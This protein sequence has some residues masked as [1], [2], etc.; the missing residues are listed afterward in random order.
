MIRSEET[1]LKRLKL[2]RFRGFESLDAGLERTT[3]LLGPNSS[4][5]TSVLHAIRMAI[6]ALDLALDQEDSHE[7][8]GRIRVCR[9]LIVQD[10]PRLVAVDDWPEVFEGGSASE[11]DRLDV[12]LELGGTSSEISNIDVSISYGRNRQPKLTVVVACP[13]ALASVKALPK[14][15]PGRPKRLGDEVRRRAPR[16]LLVPAFYGVTRAEEH[17]SQGLMSRLLVGGEQSR[18]VRNLVVRLSKERFAGLNAFLRRSIG[19][20]IV[21]RTQGDDIEH[22]VH[23]KVRFRDSNGD[24][25]LA[26]AGAGLINLIALYS[27]LAFF[28]DSQPKECSLIYLLDE[29][30]AH[31][32]PR[33]QGDVGE[34]M[35]SLG[36]EFDAQLLMAT[37][38][39]EIANRV[40]RHPDALLLGVDRRSNTAT[41]LSSESE[42]VTELSRW[43]DLSPFASI[44]FLASRR[45]L[46]HEGPSDQTILTSCARVLFRNRPMELERFARWTFVCLHGVGNVNAQAVLGTVLTPKVFPALAEL[47]DV[48]A[49]CVLDR[50]ANPSR[51]PGGRELSRLSK[52]GYRAYEHVWSRYSIESLFL[53]TACLAAWLRLYLPEALIPDAELAKSIE[54]A[55]VV[56]DKDQQLDDQT[57]DA[58]RTSVLRKNRP[59]PEAVEEARKMGRNHPAIWQHGRARA[60]LIL[61]HVRKHLPARAQNKV[62]GSVAGFVDVPSECIQLGDPQILVP[63]DVR[64]LLE[65]LVKD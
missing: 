54:E 47:G 25:E 48:R 20:E 46:F 11:G 39:V 51:E 36:R 44:N 19:A 5:K 65:W 30:E 35:A 24:L 41:P 33:L 8:Q 49:V 4:G 52:G 32:H 27:A 62:R 53:D 29:P 59:L 10:F 6:E 64:D 3:V 63:K 12:K 18:V 13:P 23:L 31:L 42:L 60:S 38:S 34:A 45:I 9:D 57:Q 22:H 40:G 2:T 55:L 1:L 7:E 56:A 14:K 16:A 43:C 50:D 61:G 37:H 28:R 21:S 15:S 17:R 26:S 58:L